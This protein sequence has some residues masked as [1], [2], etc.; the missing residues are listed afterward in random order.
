MRCLTAGDSHGE[1]LVGIVEGFPAGHR[2]AVRDIERDLDRRRTS[3]GRSAR[4]K[5]EHD[6][7]RIVSGIW[8]GR[9]TGAP[10][11]ILVENRG[12]TVAGK[13]GG[14]LSSIPRPGHAD[15]AGAMKYG[16]DEVPP[17][18]ERASARGTALRVAIGALAKSVLA[19]FSIDTLGHVIAIGDV[20]VARSPK[21]FAGLKRAVLRSPLFCG[22]PQAGDRMAGAIRTAKK[23]G[24]SLGGA[25]EVIVTG[26]P[27][28]LGSYADPDRRLDARLAGAMMSIQSVK[29]VEIGDGLKTYRRTGYESQD[30]IHMEKSRI[31]RRTNHA[32]G[33][34]GGVTNG[35]DIVIRLY[36]KPLPTSLRRLPSYNMKTRKP[37]LAPF[38]RSDACVMP[39]LSVIGEAVVAWEILVALTEKFGGDTVDEMKKSYRRYTS[40]LAKRGLT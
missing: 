31:V 20:D 16:F 11:A 34:E 12:R 17:V 28:G 23:K 38:V 24:N 3:Y 21:S 36:G 18:A 2:V 40:L 14:A 35:E 25:V 13:A 33:I 37:A 27:P 4:Q 5:L 6:S 22:D 26:V 9:S 39:A 10:I 1:C 19:L 15:F 32:G 30:A 8:K 29:A 7:V